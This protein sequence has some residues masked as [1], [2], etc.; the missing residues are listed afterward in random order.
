[1]S[2]PRGRWPQPLGYCLDFQID[3]FLV[4][5]GKRRYDLIVGV[6]GLNALAGIVLRNLGFAKRAVF[7]AIDF[8]PRRF[9]NRC[10][11]RLYLATDNL[12]ATWA[13]TTWSVS[14]RICRIRA[15][16]GLDSRRNIHVPI[17]IELAEVPT[18][19]LPRE[20]F[21]LVLASYLTESK[22]AELAVEVM[23]ELRGKLPNV[24]LEIIGTGPHE[25]TLKNLVRDR[26]L[27]DCISFLG[28]M[29]HEKLMTLLQTRGVG[30]ATY[31]EAKYSISYYADP[32]K[33]KE[34]LACG[35]PVIITRVPWIAR[36]ISDRPMGIAI[37]DDRTEFIEAATRLLT[38]DTFYRL[39]HDNAIRYTE[40]LN[41]TDIFDQSFAGTMQNAS[42]RVE[43]AIQTD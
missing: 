42:Y 36:E 13:D 40:S 31:T 16:Q 2:I 23:R 3:V 30:V 41:W 21:T 4:L 24:R 11:N 14:K 38:D 12:C 39:C 28:V 7:Y 29:E 20:R 25:A 9:G 10:L 5:S 22:G 34:Y 19:Q 15:I 18:V 17:G 33:P 32:T 8:T 35:L 1:M 27:E 43:S 37:N 6:D 26:G